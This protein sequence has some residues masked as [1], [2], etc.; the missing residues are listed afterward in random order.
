MK[1][2]GK[3]KRLFIV[4]FSLMLIICAFTAPSGCF[5][6]EAASETINIGVPTDRCPVFYIDENTGDITGIGVD[7]MKEAAGEAGFD[8]NFISITEGTIKE[9]LDNPAYDLVM[10]MGSAIKSSAE[11]PTII[12]DNL[13][14]TP[15]TLVTLSERDI[16]SLT[17][18]RVGMVSS[19]KGVSETITDLYPG[20]EVLFFDDM[21]HAVEALRSRNVD[22]LLHNSYVW[23]Y[24]LQKPSYSDLKVQPSAM[25]SM[26]FRAGALD[27]ARGKEIIE[28]LDKG[29]ASMP[30]TK[31][32]AI[33]LDHTT[34]K[35]YKYDLFDYI[36][37][38]GILIMAIVLLIIIFFVV[39]AF[40]QH[41][42]KLEHEERMRQLMDHDS[43]T[44][45]Y[46]LNGF[47]K[48]VEELLKKNPEIPYLLCFSNIRDFKFINDK[49]GM[50]AGDELLRFWADKTVEELS[51]DEAVARFE[52]DH[53]AVL[54]KIRG[55]EGIKSD[56]DKV[57]APL[58]DFFINRGK[59]IKVQVCSG[60]YVLNEEDYAHPNVARMLDYARMTEKRV[61]DTDKEGYG[62][63]N[64]DQ[65]EMGK[66]FSDVV[67]YLPTAIAN[68]E[69]QVWYQPQIDYASRCII[70][71]EAL[72]RWNHPKLGWISPGEL[73]PILEESGRIYDLDIFVWEKVCRDLKRWKLQGRHLYASVNLSR[74]DMHKNRDIPK[75]F[76]ELV[77]RHGITPDQLRIEITESAFVEDSVHLIKTAEKLKKLGFTVE[78]DDFGSGYSSLNMLKEVPVDRIKLDM[79]FLTDSGNPKKSK[80]IISH[81]IKMAQEL[82]IGLITEGVED[83]EQAD[84]LF[85]LGCAE[86]QGYYFYKPMPLQ[87]YEMIIR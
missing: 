55:N 82:N 61:Q 66:R 46:S 15:F 68:G 12:S 5:K 48:R 4:L 24:I 87:E 57:I 77:K 19:M 45:T 40:N 36:H 17:E 76:D 44:G 27:S 75:Y 21:S 33:I 25:F 70:G 26:D 52:G 63:Y 10:P 56:E 81:M 73:I 64:P 74:F 58:R 35:L 28:R 42:V 6:S 53:L 80:I 8:P 14:Q 72:C 60:L 22:A 47:K 30:E 83:K 34:R 50:D 9:A 31:R 37:L 69:I 41:S 71:A 29:I 3:A 54:R 49:L 78:M 67:G 32:Q 13:T 16:P 85:G 23:S 84:F 11:N 43:L 59:E 7:L 39:I 2:F 38:Y 62:F 1:D 86:M 65:W 79:K 20:I 18:L 51:E